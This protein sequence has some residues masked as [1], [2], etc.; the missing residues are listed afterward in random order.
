MIWCPIELGLWFRYKISLIKVALIGMLAGSYRKKKSGA[1]DELAK[2]YE[3]RFCSLKFCKS[4]ALGGHMNR[5]RQ[6]IP[7]R[8]II[9]FFK[10]IYSPLRILPERETETL[11]KARQLVFTNDLAPTHI[12]Y[13]SGYV[14]PTRSSILVI[15]IYMCVWW[16]V[17]VGS[18][19]H[20]IPHG[21]DPPLPFRSMYPT[22]MFSPP[23]PLIPPPPQQYMYAS[24]PRILSFHSAA[25]DYFVGHALP[26]ESNYTCVGAPVGHGFPSGGGGGGVSQEEG[27]NWGRR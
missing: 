12:G 27:L 19:H 15:C 6:G 11:N 1:K 4:Q 16:C 26:N 13:V 9:T 20:Q 14:D 2:V 7:H 24:P 22:R 21:G 23:S 8:L 17:C 3:C 18:G 5:H 10:R 25:N